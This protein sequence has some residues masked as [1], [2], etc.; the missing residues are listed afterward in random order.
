MQGP[1][2][3]GK[4]SGKKELTDEIRLAHIGSLS[5]ERKVVLF[6]PFKSL[7]IFFEKKYLTVLASL[8]SL[9]G[10]RTSE[11]CVRSLKITKCDWSGSK[12]DQSILERV[13]SVTHT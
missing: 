11:K 4:F 2:G 7:I 12:R 13:T 1:W 8:S 9:E 6:Q 10:F 5:Q 3:H